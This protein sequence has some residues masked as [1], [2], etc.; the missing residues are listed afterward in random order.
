MACC[1]KLKEW[2]SR[3]LMSLII[4]ECWCPREFVL[5]T[6]LRL[7]MSASNFIGILYV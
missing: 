6:L 2:V 7:L 5:G 4:V 3:S 1:V